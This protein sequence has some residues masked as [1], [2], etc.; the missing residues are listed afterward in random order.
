MPGER[1]LGVQEGVTMEQGKIIL[2][3]VRLVLTELPEQ[4]I[5]LSLRKSNR[6]PF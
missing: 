3:T 5:L 6:E 2:E 4:D 1:P